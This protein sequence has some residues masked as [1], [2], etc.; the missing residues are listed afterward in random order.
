VTAGSVL[1]GSVAAAAGRTLSNSM[2]DM[3][4]K[5]TIIMETFFIADISYLQVLLSLQAET[6][7]AQPLS[8]L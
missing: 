3:N 5:A 7:P 8:C 2:P 4:A 1:A 6:V